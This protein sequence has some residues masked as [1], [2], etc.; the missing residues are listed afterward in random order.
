MKMGSTI[1][2]AEDLAPEAVHRRE[3]LVAFRVQGQA[4]QV[5]VG[6][7]G[8]DQA[9]LPVQSLRRR[10]GGVVEVLADTDP[11]ARANTLI[12]LIHQANFLLDQQLLALEQ[13]FISEG[14]YK[15]QLASARIAERNKPGD[16][17]PNCPNCGKPMSLRTARQGKNEGSR[18]WG[19]SGYPECRQTMQ[20]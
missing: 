11:A 12:C 15:E 6:L 7:E 9:D 8:H 13:S 1:L 17:S 3:V 18:F 14:G 5:R 2:S 10:P 16:S 20:M 4:D 19:C